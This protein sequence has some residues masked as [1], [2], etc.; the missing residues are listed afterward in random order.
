MEEMD[1]KRGLGSNI[2]GEKLGELM[3]DIFGNV[4][5]DG[6]WFVSRYGAMQPI[7]TKLS[8]TSSL[9]ME[10]VTVKV[11][12]DEVLGT[13]RKRNA[14]LERATGFNSKQ[15][16]KRLKAKAKKDGL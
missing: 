11:P 16:L 1:V 8:S 12:D 15:R 2:E 4:E 6:D 9:T 7:R 3:K 10:I 13:M 14:F 5:K